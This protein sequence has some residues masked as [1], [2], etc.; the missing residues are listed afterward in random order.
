[1]L[2]AAP[3]TSSQPPRVDRVGRLAP[4]LIAAIVIAVAAH[5]ATNAVPARF[6][7]APIAVFA[8]L[9]IAFIGTPRSWGPGASF[10]LKWLLRAGIVLLGAQ[11]SLGLLAE[12]GGA[13]VL[14]I[15]F[16]VVLALG[17]GLGRLLG[18]PPSLSLVLGVGMAICGNT[19]IITVAPVIAADKRDQSYTVTTITVLG[20]AAV[21]CTR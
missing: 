19:S 5:W 9:A 1:M 6:S 7:E 8:R 13:V 14:V 17:V 10:A 12:V 11:L 4:G 3:V 18:V 2:A 20:T 16:D 15:V 21:L